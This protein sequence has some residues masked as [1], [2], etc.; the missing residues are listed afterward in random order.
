MIYIELEQRSAE[1]HKWRSKG[2]TATEAV[3]ISG[4]SEFTTPWRVWAEKTGRVKPVD[5]SGNPYVQYGIDHEDEA[6]DIFMTKHTD[7]V[8]PTCGES[9]ENRIFRASFDGL[10]S[11]GEPVEIKCPGESTLEDV[12]A[13]G[14]NSD[15]YQHYRWQVQWQMLVAGASQ[16][17]LVFFLGN[18][19]VKEFLIQRDE[20]MISEMKDKCLT[21]WN[22][23]ILGDKAPEKIPDRDIYVPKGN[24]LI[25]WGRA[26]ADFRRIKEEINRLTELLE[27]PKKKLLALMGDFKNADFYG[28]TICQ[29]TQRGS[30][31]YKKV[32]AKRGLLLTEDEIDSC[33]RDSNL[34]QKF[35]LSKSEFPADFVPEANEEICEAIRTIQNDRNNLCW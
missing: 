19:R 31:D 16:G 22:R 10:T 27:E 9:D 30:I 12:L 4:H 24:D 14:E 17:W 6:R 8:M 13:R 26:A 32:L 5:L 7:I 21:F 25:A 28:V 33:R 20:A 23:N 34:V 15:A 1:W 18:G 29:Y 11:A 3:T 2:I 35:N